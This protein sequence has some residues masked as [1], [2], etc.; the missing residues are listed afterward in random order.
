MKEILKTEVTPHKN[1]ARSSRK[2]RGKSFL[3][4]GD[5]QESIKK[6]KYTF[7]KRLKKLNSDQQVLH[8]QTHSLTLNNQEMCQTLGNF[9]TKRRGTTK[10]IISTLTKM[11]KR[12]SK[13]GIQLP[14]NI[15]T[16]PG[17][18]KERSGSFVAN[19]TPKNFHETIDIFGK[20]NNQDMF[21][22]CE[23]RTEPKEHQKVNRF[24]VFGDLLARKKES[25]KYKTLD[26]S[27]ANLQKKAGIHDL[28]LAGEELKKISDELKKLNKK[29]KKDKRKQ[30]KTK[31]KKI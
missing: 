21:E 19:I 28:E 29:I 18:L 3:G 14:P 6:Y 8:K 11:H 27:L 4:F 12:Y 1:E 10:S 16:K 20:E 25:D 17:S 13:R 9:N 24:N 23:Y 7:R 31:R 15:S 26:K 30:K 5:I 22:T 2:R